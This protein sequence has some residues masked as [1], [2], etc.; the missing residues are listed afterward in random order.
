MG[1]IEEMW[2]RRQRN[3]RNHNIKP[4]KTL[5]QKGNRGKRADTS[6]TEP[7]LETEH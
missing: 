4:G 6:T 1:M 3:Y 2:W 5:Q 7:S